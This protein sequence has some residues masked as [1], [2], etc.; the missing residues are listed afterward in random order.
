M[1][2]ITPSRLERLLFVCAV[3]ATIHGAARADDAWTEHLP[4]QDTYVDSAAARQNGAYGDS[5][6]IVIGNGREG[7]LMFDV[8]DLANVIPIPCASRNLY[9]ARTSFPAPTGSRRGRISR[10]TSVPPSARRLPPTRHT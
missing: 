2:S 9:W 4:V 3:A 10:L 1:S 8:S 7:C 6:G 5:E